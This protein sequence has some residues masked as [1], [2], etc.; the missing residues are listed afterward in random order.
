M[1]DTDPRESQYSTEIM[2]VPVFL[3]ALENFR[4]AKGIS[5][6]ETRT[7]NVPTKGTPLVD[8]KKGGFWPFLGSKPSGTLHMTIFPITATVFLYL[9][10]IGGQ[11]GGINPPFCP[12][13]GPK[14]PILPL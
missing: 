9:L 8:T 6:T 11:Y 4:V 1:A 7:Q 14:I 10:V 3:L 2:L 12:N 5:P 13:R